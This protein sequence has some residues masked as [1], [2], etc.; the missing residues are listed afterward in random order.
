MAICAEDIEQIR[1]IVLDSATKTSEQINMLKTEIV[2]DINALSNKLDTVIRDQ[3]VIS[4]RV[5][6]LEVCNMILEDSRKKQ[7][8]R[9]GECEKK[10]AV[11]NGVDKGEEK[12]NS[13][14][15]WIIPVLLS[16]LSVAITLI[17]TI[18]RG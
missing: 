5:T 11:I 4:E 7:G 2:E 6:K 1:T 18:S 8:R 10:I 17:V 3:N 9:I 12:G 14:V 15:R 16:I 13:L